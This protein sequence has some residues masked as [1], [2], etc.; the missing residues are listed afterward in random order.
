[1]PFDIVYPFDHDP[2]EHGPLE[3][4][5]PPV[6]P[7]RARRIAADTAYT[8]LKTSGF[9]A[10]TLLMTLGLPLLVFLLLVGWDMSLLFGQLDNLSSRFMTADAARRLEF[11]SDLHILFFVATGLVALVRLPGFVGDLIDSLA[12]EDVQ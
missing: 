2:D 5:V 9:V 3:P 10:T 11:A 7:R 12:R 4:R 8:L 6:W 1:M